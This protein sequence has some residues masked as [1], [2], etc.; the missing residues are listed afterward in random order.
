[1]SPPEASEPDPR[2][3]TW[4][5]DSR[6]DVYS[7]TGED[8]V[9]LAIL[10]TVAE[11][12]RWCAELGAWDGQLLS[13][14]CNLI[15]NRDYRAVLI[16]GDAA[17]FERLRERHGANERVSTLHRMVGLGG[18]NGLDAAL[19]ATPIS[20]DFDFLSID[21][22]GND[23]HIWASLTDYRPKVV[24][25]E[26]NP[27]IAT[28]VEF[29]QEPDPGVSQGSSLRSLVELGGT[30]GYE[31]VAVLP[32][33]AFFVRSEYFSRFGIADNRPEVLRTDTSRVTH[34]FHGF[35]GTLFL[36]GYSKIHWHGLDLDESR[37]QQVPKIF[38]RYPG[39]FGR[40]TMA[41]FR[42]YRRLRGAADTKGQTRRL[43]DG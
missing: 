40:T 32:F 42:W 38:R 20:E 14:T 3:A 31:L 9:V 33:N 24:C 19:S 30:K 11:N 13:N 16:E 37:I 7:Q 34:I 22:D 39:T 41:L 12:D 1:M 5:L 26:F 23:Y 21:V 8:G 27:T 35:D 10:E 36:R 29:V 18:A 25:V 2:P 43:L 28:E 17:K 6:A 4:L 15:E